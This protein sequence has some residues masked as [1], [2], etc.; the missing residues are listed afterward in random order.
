ML[1]GL[2]GNE[3]RDIFVDNLKAVFFVKDFAGNPDYREIKGFPDPRQPGKKIKA[4]FKDG[5]TMYG[6]TH[7]INLD[8]LGFFM[9]PSDVQCNNER[10]FAVY[11]SIEALEIDDRPIDLKAV[12][13]G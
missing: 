9:V 11:S 7:A 3:V 2:Q 12:K 4:V 1:G 5:E 13:G 8:Q 10:V 6:Y